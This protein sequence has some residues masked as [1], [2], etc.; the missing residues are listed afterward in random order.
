MKLSSKF[1]FIKEINLN[2]MAEK[3]IKFIKFQN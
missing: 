1:E 2:Q 3:T